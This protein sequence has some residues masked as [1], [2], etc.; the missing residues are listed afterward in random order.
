MQNTVQK[1]SE[2]KEIRLL[3]RKYYGAM[4][5]NDL[6]D[7]ERNEILQNTK[8]KIDSYDRVFFR[9]ALT[10]EIKFA[11]TNIYKFYLELALLTGDL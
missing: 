6:S 2:V 9:K 8:V 11:D 10:R 4:Q 3:I 7:D 5:E 1:T